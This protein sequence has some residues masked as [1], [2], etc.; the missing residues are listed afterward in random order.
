MLGH[1]KEVLTRGECVYEWWLDANTDN[2]VRVP[3]LLITSSLM[4]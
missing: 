4:H 3:L 2:V 1:Y